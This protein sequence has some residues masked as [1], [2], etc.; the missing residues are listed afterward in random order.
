V[1]KSIRLRPLAVI[2]ALMLVLAA[3]GGGEADPEVPAD[4][5]D[6]TVPSM[7]T[8]PTNEEELEEMVEDMTE[9]LEE[10]QESQ[11]GGS[12]TLTVGDQTWDF[13]SV[14]CAFGEDEIGQEGAEL[15][16]SSLQDGLQFYVSIDSFGHN[17]SLD[18]ISDFENPSVSL[19]TFGSDNFIQVDGKNISGEVGFM[20]TN[21]DSMDT[22]DGSFEATCP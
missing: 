21:S 3:C 15:V 4:Q 16:V 2:A 22:V 6:A 1:F 11:G 18:D 17:V 10:M 13:D 14:L 20:D 7:D 9:N 5:P 12:A 8:A 19:S